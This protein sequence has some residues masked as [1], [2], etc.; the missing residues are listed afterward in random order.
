MT[1]AAAEPVQPEIPR[2]STAIVGEGQTPGE[3]AEARSQGAWTLF[4]LI[5]GLLV[6]AACALV[7]QADANRRM[8]YEREKLQMDLRQIQQQVAMNRQF[9]AKMESDP[10][11]EERLAMRQMRVVRQGE[12]VLDI[13]TDDSDSAGPGGAAA[14]AGDASEMSPFAIV[15]VPPPA[16]LPEYEPWGGA[17]SALFLDSRTQLYLLG[18]ALFMVAAGLVLGDKSDNKDHRLAENGG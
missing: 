18:G 14:A 10:Q 11:L 6:I 4:L 16:P 9:L 8:V 2:G 1:E 13:K 17:I 12:R 15:R 5:A 7:P 3:G